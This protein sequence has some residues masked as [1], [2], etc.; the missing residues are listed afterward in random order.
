MTSVDWTDPLTAAK[1]AV[2]ILDA[3][4]PAD[5]TMHIWHEI[6]RATMTL[7]LAIPREQEGH[8]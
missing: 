3:L 7:R 6:G 2:A 8:Q 5:T 1:N 4:T